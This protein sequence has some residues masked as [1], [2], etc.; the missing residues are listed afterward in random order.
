MMRERLWRSTA[1]ALA[2]V[3]RAL[4]GGLQT[5]IIRLL[6]PTFL[7]GV[8]AVCLNQRHQALLVEHRF[9]KAHE[10]WGLPGGLMAR[11]EAPEIS[12]RREVL[13]E[14][15]LAVTDLS[16]LLT[17]GFG[18]FVNLV[19]LGRVDRDPSH[20]QQTEL[21]AWRWVDPATVDLPMRAHHRRALHLVSRH[22]QFIPDGEAE[23]D[24]TS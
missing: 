3:W 11:G 23:P 18:S 12:L 13:E 8:S 2:L 5:P 1:P 22:H 7:V 24:K 6:A 21:T 15:G 14:T 4:P 10:R 17:D 16:P 19:F 20:L 9:A